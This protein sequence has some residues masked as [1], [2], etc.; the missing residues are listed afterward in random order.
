M[1]TALA[2]MKGN[3]MDYNISEFRS[4]RFFKIITFAFFLILLALGTNNITAQINN[5]DHP[6][7][8]HDLK[9]TGRSTYKDVHINKLKWTSITGS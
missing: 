5:S 1:I 9:H 2:N 7:F 3:S 4:F 8:M 6:M